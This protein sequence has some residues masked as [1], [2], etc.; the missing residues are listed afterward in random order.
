MAKDQSKRISPG[1]LA[2]DIENFDGLKE[3]AGY[4][5][6]NAR[7]TVEAM[8]TAETAMRT[9]QEVETR[10][11][12]ALATARDNAVA[13]EWNF[14]NLVLGMRDQVTAQFGRNSNEA[15]AVGRKKPSE[16]KRRGGS[17]ESE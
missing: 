16:Y 12:A 8:S 2:A 15:Q 5:P 7:Y 1:V 6:A 4:D 9:A 3:I 14:H 13:A 17:N 10:A 11:E